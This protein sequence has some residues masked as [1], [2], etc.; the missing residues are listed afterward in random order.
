MSTN[1]SI[2]LILLIEYSCRLA[3]I[4]RGF[5]QA[6]WLFLGFFSVDGLLV[7]LMDGWLRVF[8]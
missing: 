3:F 7:G 1:Q 6:F 5:P 8:A 2:E 4:Y